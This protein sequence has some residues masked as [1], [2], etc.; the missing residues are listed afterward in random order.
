MNYLSLSDI[1]VAILLLAIDQTNANKSNIT[2]TN[3]IAERRCDFLRHNTI[4]QFND[5][6]EWI[7]RVNVDDF[8][9][10]ESA[11]KNYSMICQN[12]A[13]KKFTNRGYVLIYDLITTHNNPFTNFAGWKSNYTDSF[14][15]L[16]DKYVI[17]CQHQL[18]TFIRKLEGAGGNNTII[19][20]AAFV[21]IAIICFL[22]V[23][24]WK[25][26]R[27]HRSTQQQ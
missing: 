24:F 8:L 16:N 15:C 23:Y 26:R 13:R 20:V 6:N 21:S 7:G 4:L 10:C 25:R 3:S 2:C 5:Y 1:M 12:Q 18:D 19:V 14:N 22:A 17:V 11:N 27:R 9:Q